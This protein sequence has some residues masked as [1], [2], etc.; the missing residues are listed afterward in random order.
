MS[1]QVE[2]ERARLAAAA[3]WPDPGWALLA[4]IRARIMGDAA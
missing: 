2:K 1:Q 4:E 3:A